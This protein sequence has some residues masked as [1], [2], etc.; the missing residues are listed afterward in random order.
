MDDERHQR[1]APYAGDDG[2][3]H[4]RGERERHRR[5]CARDEQED[6]HVVDAP[7]H[8]GHAGRPVAEVVG[9]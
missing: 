4:M 5:I 9:G 2:V 8:V 7:Q 6:V 3:A 1:A